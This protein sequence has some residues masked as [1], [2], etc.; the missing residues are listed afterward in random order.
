MY[1]Y[2]IFARNLDPVYIPGNDQEDAINTFLS[3]THFAE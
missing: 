3:C 1:I 2:Q